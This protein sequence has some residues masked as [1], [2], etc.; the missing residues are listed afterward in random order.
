ML[1]LLKSKAMAS[2]KRHSP[3][4]D[5]LQGLAAENQ[6][7]SNSEFLHAAYRLLLDR[8][9][10]PSAIEY[11]TSQLDSWRLSRW[12]VLG[13][14][15]RSTE[16]LTKSWDDREFWE[17]LHRARLLI[18]SMLP[19]ADTIVDLGGSCQDRPEGAMVVFGYPY[20][21]K[22]LSIVELPRED[23]HELY[24]EICGEYQDTVQTPS[25]PVSY[26]YASMTD[27]SAF[28]DATVDLVY[29][30]QSIEHVTRDEAVLVLREVH[31]ILKPG[32]HFCFDTPNRAVS[33]IH[34][35]NSY[36]VDDHKYEYTHQEM[37]EMLVN[38][39]FAIEEAK[40]LV[41][42][43]RSVAENRFIPEE[44]I[45]RDRIFDDIEQ[46]YLLYYKARKV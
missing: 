34:Y 20:H 21:F 28:D 42:M 10:E 7:L 19:K 45:G 3:A 8:A 23:R 17:T 9:P 27:L 32:G 36:I 1:G 30:G 37:S 12:H 4:T 16:F 25:G 22:S 40:G 39:G 31:R 43:N 38:G 24:T 5:L 35:P 41:L 14:I 15:S 26:V 2:T 6:P 11:F 29:S 46:C 44:V 18:N 13:T 33:K